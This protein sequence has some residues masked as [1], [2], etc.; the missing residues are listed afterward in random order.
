MRRSGLWHPRPAALV[1][2][3][4]H[5]DTLVVADAALPVPGHVEAVDLLW[6]RGNPPILRAGVSL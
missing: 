1:T 2:V 4:G 3:M 5:C 6:V